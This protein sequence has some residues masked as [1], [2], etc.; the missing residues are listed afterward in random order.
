MRAVHVRVDKQGLCKNPVCNNKHLPQKV[1]C[2]TCAC[3]N[4]KCKVGFVG[5]AWR[6]YCGR[7]MTPPCKFKGCGAKATRLLVGF[8][9]FCNLH[10]ER[11]GPPEPEQAKST[12]TAIS[13]A[14]TTA[15]TAATTA[16]GETATQTSNQDRKQ[17]EPRLTT[18]DL[19]KKPFYEQAW[20]KYQQALVEYSKLFADNGFCHSCLEMHGMYLTVASNSNRCDSCKAICQL[21]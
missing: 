2:A 13:T 10:N 19:F 12:V 3:K 11:S 1:S 8:G 5:N 6:D 21:P 9:Y 7:C 15:T 4:T 18:A 17:D 20:K 14:T 16:A